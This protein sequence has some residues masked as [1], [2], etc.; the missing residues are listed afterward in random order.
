[1]AA[2]Y[3]VLRITDGVT[4]ADLLDGTNYALVANGWSP[5]IATLQPDGSYSDVVENI[6]IDVYGTSALIALQRVERIVGLLDQARRWS[7]GENVTPVRIE[8]QP[9]GVTT[10]A[11]RA[12]ILGGEVI[13]PTDWAD[14]LVTN[15]IDNVVIRLTRR[16]VWL[17]NTLTTGTETDWPSNVKN[18]SFGATINRYSPMSLEIS[19]VTFD[20]LAYSTWKTGIW[21]FGVSAA[22]MERLDAQTYINGVNASNISNGTAIGNSFTRL[23]GSARIDVP[24]TSS[25]GALGG[26]KIAVFAAIKN[27]TSGL[28]LRCQQ[29]NGNISFS[30]HFFYAREDNRVT[31]IGTFEWNPATTHVRISIPISFGG[32]VVDIDYLMLVNVSDPNTFIIEVEEPVISYLNPLSAGSSVMRLTNTPDTQLAPR[33]SLDIFDEGEIDLAYYGNAR[34]SARGTFS[35]VNLALSNSTSFWQPYNNAATDV[36]DHAVSGSVIEGFLTLQ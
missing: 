24:L 12:A 25:P 36:Q 26:R 6:T 13:L 10:N 1:M 20:N 7:L 11:M 17:R 5:Q 32:E 4:T 28:R 31:F 30:E 27:S 33:I 19:G 9:Q 35:F 15:S 22:Q 14:K 18:F 3:T 8:A 16:G 34:V 23:S 21:V 29:T 2:N